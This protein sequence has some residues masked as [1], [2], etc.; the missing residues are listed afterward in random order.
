MLR[1]LAF[2][3]LV[4]LSSC[5]SEPTKLDPVRDAIQTCRA[6]QVNSC[7]SYYDACVGDPDC[8]ACIDAP[9]S[10]GCLTQLAFRSLAF[11]SCDNCANEC[12]YVCPGPPGTC[13][14]CALAS[15]CQDERNAC[16]SATDVQCKPCVE[17]PFAEGCQEL[18][19]YQELD[20]CICGACGTNCVWECED[21]SGTCAACLTGPCGMA[22]STCMGDDECAACFENNATPG[23]D[24]NMAFAALGECSC[25]MCT[26]ECG[27]LF[28][29]A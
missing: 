2:L 10:L 18:P 20:A 29:C 11:C 7:Q 3:A 17:D 23:C 9:I 4:L 1:A 28:T 25:A 22:F 12:G 26:A 16:L 21:A 27:P 14:D 13:R 5:F 19:L 24:E 15:P 8:D 6:C